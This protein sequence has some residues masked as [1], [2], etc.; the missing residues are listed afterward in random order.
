MHYLTVVVVEVIR[1]GVNLEPFRAGNLFKERSET[2]RQAGHGG[3][4][5]K[6]LF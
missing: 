4:D 6:I 5:P 1:S 3:Q 2:V